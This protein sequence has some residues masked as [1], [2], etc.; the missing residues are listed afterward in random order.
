MVLGPGPAKEEFWDEEKE[1]RGERCV[2]AMETGSDLDGGTGD[3]RACPC[4]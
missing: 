4:P 3:A 2:G 1:S